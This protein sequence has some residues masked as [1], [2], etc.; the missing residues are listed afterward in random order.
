M[1]VGGRF[2]SG[3]LVLCGLWVDL[4][5]WVACGALGFGLR[6]WSE[7]WRGWLVSDDDPSRDDPSRDEPSR[8][9][10]S[11]GEPSQGEPSH[12]D[13]SPLAK[14]F[15][16]ASRIIV[17]G[18]GL[19][20]LSWGGYW[21]DQKLGWNGPLLAVGAAIGGFSFFWQMWKLVQELNRAA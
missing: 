1:A 18:T 11:Q 10:P 3:Y 7:L 2:A 8:D 17:A 14:G 9:E 21:L 5:V 4:E 12:D 16:L 15:D 13:R 20:L 6:R 19:G